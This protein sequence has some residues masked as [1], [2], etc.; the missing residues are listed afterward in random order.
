MSCR[1]R[2]TIDVDELVELE[3]RRR[4][5]RLEVLSEQFRGWEGRQLTP[6]EIQTLGMA[7]TFAVGRLHASHQD[8]ESG[9]C[10]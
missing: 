8:H 1:C 6:E 7:T 4:A 10:S 5:R 3:A 2:R 9:D